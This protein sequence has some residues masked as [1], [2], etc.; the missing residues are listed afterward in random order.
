MLEIMFLERSN[1]LETCD[2]NIWKDA[3]EESAIIK[4]L[5]FY[6]FEKQLCVDFMDMAK[7]KA[8]LFSK[9]KDERYQVLIAL[10]ETEIVGNQKKCIFIYR[11]LFDSKGFYLETTRGEKIEL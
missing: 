1:K 10:V 5:R 4:N 11:T 6:K 7:N 9:K 8:C 3:W 2:L